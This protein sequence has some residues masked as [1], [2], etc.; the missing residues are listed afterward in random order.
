[1]KLTASKTAINLIAAYCNKHG[2][3]FEQQD[4]TILFKE[5]TDPLE[6]YCRGVMQVDKWQVNCLWEYQLALLK[7]NV[8]RHLDFAAGMKLSNEHASTDGISSV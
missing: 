8:P 6:S 1:M 5:M 2:I 7:N 4:K 3:T